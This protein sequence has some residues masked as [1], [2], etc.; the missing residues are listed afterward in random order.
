ML[1]KFSALLELLWIRFM[2]AWDESE[3]RRMD[4]EIAKYQRIIARCDAEI[5]K[6]RRNH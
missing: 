6:Q 5:A 1:T 3:L 2:I 4:A